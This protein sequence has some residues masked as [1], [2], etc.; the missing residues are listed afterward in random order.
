MASRASALLANR[1]SVRILVARDLKVRYADSLLGWVWTVLEPLLMALVF[2]FVF[3]QIFHRVGGAEPYIVFLLC[4]LLPWNFF[5]AVTTEAARALTTEAKLVRSTNLPREVWVL[6]IVGAKLVEFVLSLP[7]IAIF[8]IFYQKPP[9]LFIVFFPLALLIEC[10]LVTGVALLLAPLT[11]LFNDLQRL[12]R[13]FLRLLFYMSPV[14]YGVHNVPK[15]VRWVYELNPLSGI[16]D[17]YRAGVFRSEFVG[18]HIVG[19]SVVGSCLLF[20]LG[21]T[22][23]RRLE[24]TVLKEI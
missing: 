21:T 10:I 24:G 5:N 2:W 4:G 12:V 6:R 22:V 14:L 23:F 13:I 8:M 17:L 15:N 9:D 20:A 19:A 3:T 7:V 16:L 18:W 1:G 11:V